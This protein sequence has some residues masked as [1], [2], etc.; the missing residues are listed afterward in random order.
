MTHWE[1]RAFFQTLELKIVMQKIYK[2]MSELLLIFLGTEIGAALHTKM[3]K[4]RPR[5]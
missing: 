1:V 2:I 5:K 3:G 4:R